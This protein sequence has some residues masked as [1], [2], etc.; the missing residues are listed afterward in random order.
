MWLDVAL[1]SMKGDGG[2]KGCFGTV[3]ACCMPPANMTGAMRNKFKAKVQM[4]VVGLSMFSALV[5]IGTISMGMTAIASAY[6][7]LVCIGISITYSYGGRAL[8]KMLDSS[9]KHGDETEVKGGM[10]RGCKGSGSSGKE[11]NV[12]MV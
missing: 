10:C 5:F 4:G 7:M 12:R 8:S 6:M 2:S 11:V 1:G 3:C 9:P